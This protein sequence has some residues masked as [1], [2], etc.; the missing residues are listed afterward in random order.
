MDLR[1]MIFVA[2]IVFTATPALSVPQSVQDAC[3][4]TAQ[5]VTPILTEPEKEQYV[6]N[7]IVDYTA[8]SPPPPPG[9]KN[10]DRNRY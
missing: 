4:R 6:A 10:T 3:W 1:P 8:G 7:C 9:S 2:G 5:R